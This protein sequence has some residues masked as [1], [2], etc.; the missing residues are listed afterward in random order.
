[1]RG[2]W[3]RGPTVYGIRQTTQDLL[4]S[5]SNIHEFHEPSWGWSTRGGPRYAT[6]HM[7]HPA[8]R[9]YV[10]ALK[11]ASDAD[12]AYNPHSNSNYKRCRATYRNEQ[13]I[14]SWW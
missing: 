11:M 10:L 2:G 13:V 4:L 6:G 7:K 5:V 8:I 1:M 14:V 3:G 12:W 9:L